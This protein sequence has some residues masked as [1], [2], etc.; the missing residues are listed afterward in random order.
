MSPLMDACAFLHK[1]EKISYHMEKHRS[2]VSE[3]VDLAEITLLERRR[4][5]FVTDE[6]VAL[7]YGDG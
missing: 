4:L 5:V 2:G 3:A 6:Q 7:Q 1:I